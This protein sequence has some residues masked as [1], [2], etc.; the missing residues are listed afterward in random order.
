MFRLPVVL[1]LCLLVLSDPA[2]AQP[3]DA[4]P[5]VAAERAFAADAQVLGLD[6]AFL[7]WSSED[8]VMIAGGAVRRTHQVFAP[9]AV[10]DP[11]AP[12][13][14]WRPEWAGIAK[15]G[16]IGFT[17]GPFEVGGVRSGAYFTIWARQPEGGWKWV[18]DGGVGAIPAHASQAEGPPAI[19]PTAVLGSHG[20]EAALS[21]VRAVEAVLAAAALLDQK[22]AHLALMA[23]D[24]RLHVA[25]R[26]P[27]IGTAAF[28]AALDGWPPRLDLG[29]PLGGG[30][31]EAGDMVWTYGRAEWAAGAGHYV[32][33][34]QKRLDGWV[35]VFAQIITDPAPPPARG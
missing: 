9:G 19:L 14:T 32:H 8:A 3:A 35:L 20:S 15:S 6:A 34:W 4:A 17:S 31:S 10:A 2:A 22:Q 5:V 7:K 11:A 28:P 27:A 29:A 26:P 30:S 1:G 16:D 23:P 12:A 25:A 24:G 13:L 33:L 18:Y 21:E